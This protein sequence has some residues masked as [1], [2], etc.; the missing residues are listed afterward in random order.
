MRLNKRSLHI[1]PRLVC[2]LRYGRK[3]CGRPFRILYPALVCLVPVSYT[4]LDV[5][6]RQAVDEVGKDH[7]QKALGAV[8]DAAKGTREHG[9]SNVIEC[10]LDRGLPQAQST[11]LRC[12]FAA[13]KLGQ[14]ALQQNLSLIHISTTPIWTARPAASAG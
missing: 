2:C 13:G 6:K 12:H 9:N 7:A 11:A 14:A 5:Y 10:V 8:Q 1:P 3:D 4:H